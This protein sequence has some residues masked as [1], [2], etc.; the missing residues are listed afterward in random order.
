MSQ[1]SYQS[2]PKDQFEH[3][4]FLISKD[5]DPV[6]TF[7]GMTNRHIFLANLKGDDTMR[8]AQKSGK[9]LVKMFELARREPQLA[10]LFKAK[11]FEWLMELGITRAKDGK[12][13]DQQQ[14]G[15]NV[16]NK[17][18]TGFSSTPTQLQNEGNIIDKLLKKGQGNNPQQ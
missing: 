18:G 7:Q 10:P 6:T 16:Q 3:S 15:M 4:T 8:F 2:T 12:E 17:D 1:A 5:E 13:R 14:V 11:Y 9:I